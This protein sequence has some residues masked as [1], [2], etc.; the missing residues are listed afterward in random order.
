MAFFGVGPSVVAY[1]VLKVLE[2]NEKVKD[3][4][5]FSKPITL[6]I[7]AFLLN[8]IFNMPAIGLLA[9]GGVYL[10]MRYLMNHQYPDQ[11]SVV[12][13]NL[14]C[15]VSNLFSTLIHRTRYSIKDMGSV[16]LYTVQLPLN[17]DRNN[18]SVCWTMND[19]SAVAN[20]FTVY[21]RA[22]TNEMIEY[23]SCSISYFVDPKFVVV[24]FNEVPNRKE[25][26][27]CIPKCT[28]RS[29]SLPIH[30]CVC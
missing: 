1:A 9:L 11:A 20:S 2:D 8:R 14:M 23:C 17:V 29:Y 28:S 19:N 18:V 6:P 7:T 30:S 16:K 10:G 15:D 21:I 27:V 25:L 4:I 5:P 26:C 3:V 12:L 13:N 24:S 22:P